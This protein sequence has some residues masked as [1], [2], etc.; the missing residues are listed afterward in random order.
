MV[1]AGTKLAAVMSKRMNGVVCSLSAKRN[2]GA[3]HFIAG[4]IELALRAQ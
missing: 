2:T 4:E 3:L 1:K